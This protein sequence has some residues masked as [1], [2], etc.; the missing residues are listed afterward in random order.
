MSG[1]FAGGPEGQAAYSSD[2]GGQ[3]HQAAGTPVPAP[4]G[5]SALQKLHGWQERETRVWL[6][7]LLGVCVT[8]QEEEA[9]FLDNP[10][11]WEA[12]CY[13]QVGAHYL[14]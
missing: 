7:D 13:S 8:L 6:A 5:T 10:Y 9:P 12:C 11:R 4:P 14:L 1:H 2:R 3:Q